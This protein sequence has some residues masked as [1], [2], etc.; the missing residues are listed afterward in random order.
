MLKELT[1]RGILFICLLKGRSR[2]YLDVKNVLNFKKSHSSS[3]F[4]CLYLPM[5]TFKLTQ[6][7]YYEN[8]LNIHEK[9]ILS[10][11]EILGIHSTKFPSKF[12]AMLIVFHE[13]I[14]IP[15]FLDCNTF[16][17]WMKSY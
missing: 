5:C 2:T 10:V 13:S 17:S 16:F 3:P 14:F 6:L 8:S 1:S 7:N 4:H 12:Y 15:R 11:H 9:F